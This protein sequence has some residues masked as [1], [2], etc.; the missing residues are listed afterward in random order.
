MP[1]LHVPRIPVESGRI[2]SLFPVMRS[3]IYTRQTERGKTNQFASALLMR[4]D[5]SPFSVLNF[6]DVFIRRGMVASL[7]K[8]GKE[9][10]R[11]PYEEEKLFYDRA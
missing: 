10:I 3:G 7:L 6:L 8:I 2:R 1:L 4:F 11:F 9:T 5:A